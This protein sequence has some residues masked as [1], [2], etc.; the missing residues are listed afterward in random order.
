M[1]SPLAKQIPNGATAG[2]TLTILQAASLSCRSPIGPDLVG[3]WLKN[4]RS[5]GI[6]VLFFNNHAG[7]SHPGNTTEQSAISRWVAPADLEVTVR[8][9]VERKS[10][11]GNGVKVKVATTSD[12]LVLNKLLVRED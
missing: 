10:E 12:G 1:D 4:F 8:G 3:R 5:P 9:R 11:Q 7:V 6:P 2:A